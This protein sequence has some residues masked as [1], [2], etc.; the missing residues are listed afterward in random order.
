MIQRPDSLPPHGP[1]KH[2]TSIL[3]PI[4]RPLDVGCCMSDSGCSRITHHASRFRFF[5]SSFTTP[6]IHST[7]LRVFSSVPLHS[8]ETTPPQPPPCRKAMQLRML[9][10]L[11]PPPT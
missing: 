11:T 6:R 8:I 1:W 4:A 7:L 10:A 2:P 5:P 3:L 9:S